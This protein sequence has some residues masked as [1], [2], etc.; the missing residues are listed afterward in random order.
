MQCGGN[1]V[2]NIY[3]S[4]T[5]GFTP[6]PSNLVANAV[7]GSSYD[8]YDA[9]EF[10]TTYYYVVRA[11]DTRGH[12]TYLAVVNTAWTA[13]DGVTVRVPR[14]PT[15]VRAQPADRKLEGWHYIDGRVT[16]QAPPF[17]VHQMIVLEF[18]GS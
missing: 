11:I 13:R 18:D 6:D 1:P 3:R 17:N 4:T 7:A 16:F 5:S 8:D 10:N 15:S 12:G 2:Y 9:V 14:K